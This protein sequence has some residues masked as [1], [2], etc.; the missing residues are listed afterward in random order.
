MFLR[1]RFD[2]GSMK[3]LSGLL[4]KTL[5]MSSYHD[6]LQLIS[7]GPFNGYQVCFERSTIVKDNWS[8]ANYLEYL[9]SIERH[10]HETG[11][12]TSYEFLVDNNHHVRSVNVQIHHPERNGTPESNDLIR[13]V[14][15]PIRP[16]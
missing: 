3:Q 15:V 7:D 8:A 10:K 13:W 2:V 14:V 6:F 11:I 16:Q 5:F 9:D 1:C 12:T 4:K